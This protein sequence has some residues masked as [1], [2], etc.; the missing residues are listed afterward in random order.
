M[1]PMGGKLHKG[2]GVWGGGGGGRGGVGGRGVGWGGGR[3]CVGIQPRSPFEA[4]H[5]LCRYN[6]ESWALVRPSS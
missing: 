6:L 2:L 1:D 5:L 4:F 3:V